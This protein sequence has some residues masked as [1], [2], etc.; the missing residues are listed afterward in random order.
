M[1]SFIVCRFKFINLL[2]P[3]RLNLITCNDFLIQEFFRVKIVNVWSL[4]NLTIHHWLGKYWL[5][6]LIVTISTIS[7]YIN[8]NILVEFLPVFECHM[9]CFM[10]K[11]WFV[12][13]YMNH[14]CL[15]GFCDIS[16]I[17]TCSTLSWCCRKS[18]LIISDHMNNSSGIIMGQI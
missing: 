4:R 9:H 12:C 17:Q 3:F 2:V 16:T 1:K 8:E 13:I 6:Q 14:W 11:L 18:N 7:N 15:N 5:I 10:N